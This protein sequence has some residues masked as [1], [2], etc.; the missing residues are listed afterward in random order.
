[1]KVA[2][3]SWLRTSIILLPDLDSSCIIKGVHSLSSLLSINPLSI[4][5]SSKYFNLVILHIMSVYN[6]IAPEEDE[7]HQAI[8]SYFLGPKAENYGFFKKNI[9]EILDAQRDARLDYFPR[10]GVSSS[11]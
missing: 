8:S 3:I 5:Y 4:S 9:I 1:M 6:N 2:A 11:S 10:D 7:S